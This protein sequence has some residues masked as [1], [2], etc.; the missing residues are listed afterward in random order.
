MSGPPVS[1]PPCPLCGAPASE[2]RRCATCGLAPGF[3]PGRPNPLR[4]RPLGVLV[5]TVLV[6]YLATLGIVAVIR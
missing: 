6:V 1:V 2:D 4:G 5:V 3:G